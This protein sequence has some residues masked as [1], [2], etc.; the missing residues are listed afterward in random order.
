VTVPAAPAITSI[1]LSPSESAIDEPITAVVVWTGF[2]RTGIS[3]QWRLGTAPISGAVGAVYTPAEAHADL[4]CLIVID[5]GRGT[6]MSASV[7]ATID[8]EP[9][10]EPGA[11]SSAFAEAFG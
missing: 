8:D 1:T 3:Y 9:E 6:A 5:N 11:F 2:P 10:P 4:N 7:Y